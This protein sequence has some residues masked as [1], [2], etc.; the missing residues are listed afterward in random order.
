MILPGKGKNNTF[1]PAFWSEQGA[2]AL[3]SD[4]SGTRWESVTV[5][6]TVILVEAGHDATVHAVEAWEGVRGRDKS[7]D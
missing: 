6:S 7:G 5:P 3:L 2:G 4:N 1:A